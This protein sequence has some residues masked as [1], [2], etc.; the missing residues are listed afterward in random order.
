[1][2]KAPAPGTILQGAPELQPP[3][4][5][6]VSH[7][8]NS[9][10]VPGYRSWTGTSPH[11]TVYWRDWGGGKASRMKSAPL[12]RGSLCHSKCSPAPSSTSE[13]WRG[14]S[15]AWGTAPRKPALWGCYTWYAASLYPSS[16]S[17]LSSSYFIIS[18]NSSNCHLRE[19]QGQVT[20]HPSA[21]QWSA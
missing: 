1:M 19:E 5:W 16:N 4:H 10:R 7:G 20:V 6:I 21:A 14:V 2:N 17:S 18:H 13:K 11:P 3:Q 12:P 8:R 9:P 15:R